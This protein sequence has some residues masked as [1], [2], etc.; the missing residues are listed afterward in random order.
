MDNVSKETRSYIMSKIGGVS[1][2]ELKARP[3]LRGLMLRHQPR[4]IHGNPDFANKARKLAVFVHGCYWH[5]CPRCGFSIPAT[6]TGFWRKK[7]E[8]NVK[9][10]AEVAA[11]LTK[12]G[13]DVL[14]IWECEVKRFN[15]KGGSND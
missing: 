15:R 13:W 1:A 2:L 14:V 12:S 4:G 5:R 9:R 11:E 10:H 6:N 7:F 8:R 3:M